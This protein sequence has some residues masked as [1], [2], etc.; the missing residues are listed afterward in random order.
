MAWPEV[1]WF[2]PTEIKAAYYAGTLF[3]EWFNK[4]PPLSPA[5][6]NGHYLFRD[7]MLKGRDMSH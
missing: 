4:Y 7:K 3:R 1:T 5:N 6:L 2:Y